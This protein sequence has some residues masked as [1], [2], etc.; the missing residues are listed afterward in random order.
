MAVSLKEL[1]AAKKKKVAEEQSVVS[2]EIQKETFNDS[3]IARTE[4]NSRSSDVSVAVVSNVEASQPF[5]DSTG[6]YSHVADVT[7]DSS[8]VSGTIST[9]PEQPQHPLVMELAELRQSLEAAVPGFAIILKKIHE[10]LRQDPA[11]VTLMTEEE[12]F[13]CVSGL[14]KHAQIEVIA[15]KSIKDVKKATKGIKIGA[16]D[17]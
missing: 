15:P 12:I 16:E 7:E 11:V 1:L 4:T 13:V 2:P 10:K 6:S 9:S 14:Q 17:L 5:Y 8:D 3:Q